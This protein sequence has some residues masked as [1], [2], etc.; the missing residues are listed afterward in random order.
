MS[1][2]KIRHVVVGENGDPC[3]RCGKPTEIR[4][5]PAITGKHLAQPFYYSRW[6]YCLNPDCRTKQ[7][8]P[9][10]YMVMPKIRRDRIP[11]MLIDQL[12][13]PKDFL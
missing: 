13:P 8:M 9:D 11:Q 6:F 2:R 1:K 10:R 4:T 3:P 12:T 7:I 5:H